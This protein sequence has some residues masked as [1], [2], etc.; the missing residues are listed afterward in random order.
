MPLERNV[1][2]GGG[3]ALEVGSPF[4]ITSWMLVVMLVCRQCEAKSQLTLVNNQAARC[5]KC[6]AEYQ[7]GG[8]RWHVTEE[9]TPRLAIASS[10]P[11]RPGN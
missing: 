3:P 7:C 10:A 4:E 11:T 8:M 6:G 9:P 5:P 1:R 2:F